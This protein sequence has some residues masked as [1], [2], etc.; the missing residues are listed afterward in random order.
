MNRVRG[1]NLVELLIAQVV[2]LALLAAFLIVLLRSQRDFTGSES[3]ARLQDSARHALGVLAA[4]IEHAGFFGYSTAAQFRLVSRGATLAD[5][6]A[7]L[8][9]QAGRPT[10]AVA[11]LPAGAHDCGINFVVDLERVIQGLDNHY[12]IGHEAR[13]CDPTATAGGASDS[14]DTLTVRHASLAVSAPRAGR[15]Q[16]YSAA[17]SSAQPLLLFSDGRAPGTVDAE[18]EVRDLEIHSYYIANHSVERADESP[19]RGQSA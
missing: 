10:I 16:L 5:Q 15:L 6:P 19:K 3:L 8:Q 18:H 14:A 11:G 7:L 2:G 9:P 12:R 13:D 4:D 1:F 17:L